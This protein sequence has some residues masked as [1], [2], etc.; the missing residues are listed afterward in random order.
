MRLLW[1]PNF[2]LPRKFSPKRRIWYL[3][4]NPFRS[5]F[6]RMRSYCALRSSYFYEYI[7][8]NSHSL[9]DCLLLA[10]LSLNWFFVLLFQNSIAI[11][12]YVL[13]GKDWLKPYAAFC[14]LRDFFET[15]DHSQ[16]G[17]F[18]QYS[19]D[20]VIT[21]QPFDFLSVKL[22]SCMSVTKFVGPFIYSIQPLDDIDKVLSLNF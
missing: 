18:S 21:N 17:R 20:K 13:L 4:R 9:P 5:F 8:N 7:A 22:R 16:W 12:N 10:E 19:K 14:F 15:S 1:L 3:T 11:L 2:Q 6:L